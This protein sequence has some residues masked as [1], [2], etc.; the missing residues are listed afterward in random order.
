VPLLSLE[1]LSTLFPAKC[2]QVKLYFLSN[3]CSERVIS[4]F[5]VTCIAFTRCKRKELLESE[6]REPVT[7][8][9]RT[10]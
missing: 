9:T 2:M 1:H 8:E 4:V 3:N 6:Q 7:G 5:E 10:G